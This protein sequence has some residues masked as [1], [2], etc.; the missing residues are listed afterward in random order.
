LNLALGFDPAASVNTL[1]ATARR[2]RREKETRRSQMGHLS[3]GGIVGISPSSAPLEK[4]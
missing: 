2:I 1:H 3:D 4:R